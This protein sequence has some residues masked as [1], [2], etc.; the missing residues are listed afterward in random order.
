MKLKTSSSKCVC[1]LVLFLLIFGNSMEQQ[2]VPVLNIEKKTGCVGD[3]VKVNVSLSEAPQGISGYNITWV[4]SNASIAEIESIEIP[5]WGSNFL[6]KNSSLPAS[7]VYVRAIDLGMQVE[8]N[9]T[10]IPIITLLLRTKLYGNSTIYIS[11]FRMDD[12]DDR[13]INPVIENG[14]IF[15]Y[16]RGDLNDNSEVADIG[17]VLLIWRA[18]LGLQ[19]T[20]CRY[21]MNQNGVEADIGDVLLLWQLWQN[22]GAS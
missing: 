13:R 22:K 2:E 10:N 5:S 9:T 12:D 1:I 6:S 18:Y 20:N 3:L 7:Y 15:V 11:R 8:E 19:A 16:Q 17:D 14:S 4:L 21:D